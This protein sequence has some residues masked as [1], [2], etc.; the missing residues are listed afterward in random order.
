MNK[1]QQFIASCI[2]KAKGK[3]NV[4]KATAASASAVNM[5]SPRVPKTERLAL[6]NMNKEAGTLKTYVR[7]RS[8]RSEV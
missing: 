3:A 4:R 5:R 6:F 2:Q 7:Q 1:F 8:P